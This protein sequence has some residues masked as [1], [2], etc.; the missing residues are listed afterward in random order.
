MLDAVGTGG[1]PD[2]AA[3]ARNIL[4]VGSWM[5]NARMEVADGR[6]RITRPGPVKFVERVSETTFSG[7]QALA[8]GKNV[9]YATSVGLFQLTP[10]GMT[11]QE[12]MPGIDVRQEILEASPMKIVLPESG[13]VPCVPAEIVTG[14]GFRLSF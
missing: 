3:A 9:Y 8:A 11:L 5:A 6:I 13:D 4:F 14:K 12:V 1:L 7:P 2:L 10:R